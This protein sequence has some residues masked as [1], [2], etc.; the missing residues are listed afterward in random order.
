[1]AATGCSSIWVIVEITASDVIASVGEGIAHAS[2]AQ[3]SSHPMQPSNAIATGP[4]RSQMAN[5]VTAMSPCLLMT[6]LTLG[7]AR[8]PVKDSGCL[9]VTN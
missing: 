6:A 7:D 3:G 2:C 9:M 5:K 4:S 1:M 8:L